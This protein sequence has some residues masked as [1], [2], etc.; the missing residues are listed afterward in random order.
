MNIPIDLQ[1][2][3]CC[4]PAAQ[5]G[6]SEDFSK[7]ILQTKNE[8]NYYL[9][10][11]IVSG[12]GIHWRNLLIFLWVLRNT[13]PELGVWPGENTSPDDQLIKF[14]DCKLIRA[15]QTCKSSQ[16]VWGR[17]VWGGQVAW[18]FCFFSSWNL[19]GIIS[20]EATPAK[21]QTTWLVCTWFKHI[22][23][24]TTNEIGWF[25]YIHTYLYV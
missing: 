20:W 8:Q 12:S 24:E 21:F 11:N 3:T 10:G 19:K 22:G 4:I 2:Q 23:L 5:F 9:T 25:V 1:G 7:G 17:V 14:V 6:Q 16:G 18:E 15:I 13:K